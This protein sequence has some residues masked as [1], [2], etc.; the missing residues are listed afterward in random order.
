MCCLLFIELSDFPAEGDM[1]VNYVHVLVMP[2]LMNL[3]AS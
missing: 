1:A 3:A 2:E